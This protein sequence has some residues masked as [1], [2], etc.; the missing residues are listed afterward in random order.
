[1]FKINSNFIYINP[2]LKLFQRWQELADGKIKL[3]TVAPEL[4]NGTEFIRYLH[5]NG[6]I[7][8]IGH[9]DAMRK[10]P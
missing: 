6:V 3:V 10:F 1:M 4:D 8:S 5:E 9:S 2:D 7:A